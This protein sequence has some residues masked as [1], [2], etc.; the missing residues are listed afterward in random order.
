MSLSEN[1]RQAI[2][3]S[4]LSTYRVAKDSGV[5]QAGLQRFVA[6]QRELSLE[7]ADRLLT[8]FGMTIGKPRPPKGS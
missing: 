3:K 6:R 2:A 5:G 7:S 1:L 4:G 8:Y